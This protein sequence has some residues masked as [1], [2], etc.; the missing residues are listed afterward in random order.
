MIHDNDQ[1]CV[2]GDGAQH[3]AR[4]EPAFSVVQKA[5]WSGGGGRFA[6][7]NRTGKNQKAR[8]TRYL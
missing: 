4:G 6:S 3:A 1:I 7:W 2:R 8:K 5:I